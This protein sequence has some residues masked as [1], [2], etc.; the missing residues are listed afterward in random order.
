MVVGEKTFRGE[1]AGP[2]RRVGRGGEDIAAT[3]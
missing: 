1:L 2:F 3:I